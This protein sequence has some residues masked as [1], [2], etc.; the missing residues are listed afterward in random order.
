MRKTR[1]AVT[2]CVIVALSFAASL[3]QASPTT[4]GSP[5]GTGVKG[6]MVFTNTTGQDANDFHIE[7][8]QTDP[9]V[10]VNGATV[11]S[12][13]M[14]TANVALGDRT[15]NPAND[16]Q[17]HQASVDFSGGTVPT[18]GTLQVDITLW[19][20]K[21]NQLFLGPWYWTKDG[22][23]LAG[24]GGGNPGVDVGGPKAG[25]G[26][27]GGNPG[28]G[29]E[30][31]GGTGNH[32]HAF[33]LYNTGDKELTII[34]LRLLASMTEYTDFLHDIDWTTQLPLFDTLTI[35]AGGNWSIDFETLGS[36]SGGNIYWWFSF[37]D[38][39]QPTIFAG[40][41]P[42]PPVPEP[43]ALALLATGCLMLPLARRRRSS[44]A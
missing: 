4:V 8:F 33:T 42:V 27:G 17:N 32:T 26:G 34:G 35:P 25:G 15:T 44:V 9:G 20:T 40:K 30:G 12:S 3:S 18:L 19:L 22:V 5:T 11:S 24:G 21:K 37:I 39:P 13:A 16:G 23:P 41:H 38:D 36:F 14:G 29:Q 43:A 6:S 31:D 10:G 2:S 28:G 7:V 1:L